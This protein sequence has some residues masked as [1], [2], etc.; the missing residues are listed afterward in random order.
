MKMKETSNIRLSVRDRV[1]IGL[2]L[3]FILCAFTLELYWLVYHDEILVRAETS[4]MAYL[5]KVY[6]AADRG[7]TDQISSFA[8]ALES[9]NVYF[10]QIA[11]AWLIYAI[12]KHRPYRHALQ[13]TISSYVAYSV[14]LYFWEAYLTGF[15]RMSA[16]TAWGYFIF[17]SPNLPWLLGHLYMAVDSFI[18]IVSRFRV[19]APLASSQRLA[20]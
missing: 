6:G 4:F 9:F 14:A 8:V 3:S 11:N 5:F 1:C 16:H 15:A 18:V 20:A 13:L 19:A 12:V 2:L 7:Y 10:T 17:F